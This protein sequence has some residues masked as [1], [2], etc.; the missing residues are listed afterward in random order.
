MTYFLSG[1]ATTHAYFTNHGDQKTAGVRESHKPL[2]KIKRNI[3]RLISRHKFF[4]ISTGVMQVVG[5]NIRGS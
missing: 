4:L 5:L 2:L 1:A 3:E